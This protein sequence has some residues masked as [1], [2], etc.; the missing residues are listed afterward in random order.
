MLLEN[1]SN[2]NKLFLKN[3]VDCDKINGRL[4]VRTR[5]ASDEIRLLGRGC[6]KSLKKLMNELKIPQE[7]R[8]VI[9]VAADDD[10]VVWIYGIGVAERVAVDQNTK[11]AIEFITHNKL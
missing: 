1:F 9:P 5:N 8:D 3:A 2:V 6:T 4:T 10:G 11:K 7:L